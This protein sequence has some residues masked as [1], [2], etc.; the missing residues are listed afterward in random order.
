MFLNDVIRNSVVNAY[1]I[2]AELL[3]EP[4]IFVFSFESCS[5]V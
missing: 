2:N 1:A 3:N 4:I 5:A